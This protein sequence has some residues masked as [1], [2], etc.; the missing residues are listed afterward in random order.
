MSNEKKSILEILPQKQIFF[1]GAIVA[2]FAITSMG[3][4]VLLFSGVTLSNTLN[5]EKAL[6][7]ERAVTPPQ[8]SVAPAPPPSPTNIQIAAVTED[9]W[10]KGATNAPITIVEYSDTECPFCKQFHQ[11]MNQVIE[12]Y[13]DSVKWVYR[14]APLDSLHR[15]ARREAMALE[16]AGDIGGNKGFWSY[17]DELFRV[18]P[19]NDGLAENQLF[20]IAKN[21]GIDEKQFTDCLESEKFAAEVQADLDDAQKA[22]LRGTPY[23]VLIVG[24]KKIPISGAQSY[25]QVEQIIQSVLNS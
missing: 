1:L 3:F 24:D 21:A 16:C 15:K 17:T 14:H 10:Y 11:T 6:V 22:G 5:N 7:S 19:S 2:F 20:T 18:T 4:F 9:D 25:E 23:S 12:N 8:P 13:R